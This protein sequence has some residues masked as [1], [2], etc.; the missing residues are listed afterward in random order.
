MFLAEG[1]DMTLTWTD[2]YAKNSLIRKHTSSTRRKVYA[3]RILFIHHTRK[4][5]LR[6]SGWGTSPKIFSNLAVLVCL[7]Y[8]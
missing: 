2:T 1:R 7:P 8:L 5:G 3:L 6:E 4:D